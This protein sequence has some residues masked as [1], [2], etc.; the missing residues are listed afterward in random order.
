MSIVRANCNKIHALLRII[1]KRQSHSV[2][3]W[4]NH[5]NGRGTPR[6]YMDTALMQ[7]SLYNKARQS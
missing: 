2:A 4:Q 7:Q 5:R 6:P 1:I 3:F